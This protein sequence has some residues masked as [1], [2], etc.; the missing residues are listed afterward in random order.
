MPSSISNEGELVPECQAPIAKVHDIPDMRFDQG[1][2]GYLELRGSARPLPLVRNLILLNAACFVLWR[3]L[4][5]G[6]LGVLLPLGQGHGQVLG[7]LLYGFLH[8]NLMHLLFNMFGLWILG[9]DLLRF[10]GARTFLIYYLACL[11]GA[12]VTHL[13]LDPLF[14]GQAGIIGASGGV[15][16]LLAAYGW[17][18]GR[19]NLYLF[20]VFPLQARI[21]A[22]ALAAVSLFSGVM[23]TRDGLAHFAHLG[24]MLTGILLIAWPTLLKSYRLW[25]HRLRMQAYAR[26]LDGGKASPSGS[27]EMSREEMQR[28][29]DRLL[30]KVSRNGLNSLS[31]S[32]RRFL[33]EASATLREEHRQ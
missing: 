22:V 14:G 25:R 4:P 13:I 17:F 28:R 11:L 24:G 8:A 23:S 3:L 15:Y 21:F 31:S 12:G 20:G 5:M 16:G 10:W 27:P 29:V 2:S 1:Y 26:K 30:D 32:E 6:D 7:L 18:F 19:R 9:N 33:D